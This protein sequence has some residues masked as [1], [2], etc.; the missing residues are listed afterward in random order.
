M[1]RHRLFRVRM[2]WLVEVE[3]GRDCR[4]AI[5]VVRLNYLTRRGHAEVAG[6]RGGPS[7][8]PS[9]TSVQE[10]RGVLDGCGY[11]LPDEAQA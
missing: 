10:L 8:L 2:D 3:E 6:F 1:K 7:R 9:G 4:A 5:D 11:A